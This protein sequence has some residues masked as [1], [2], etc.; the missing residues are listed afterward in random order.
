[1]GCTGS[2]TTAPGKHLPLEKEEHTL[3]VSSS[4]PLPRKPFC[5][6]FCKRKRYETTGKIN[7][8][9]ERGLFDST[10]FDRPLLLGDTK[11]DLY[12]M[13]GS[14]IVSLIIEMLIHIQVKERIEG[15]TK[16]KSPWHVVEGIRDGLFLIKYPFNPFDKVPYCPDR[17]IKNNGRLYTVPHCFWI[18]EYY[19]TGMCECHSNLSAWEWEEQRLWGTYGRSPR[20]SRYQELYVYK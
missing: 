5:E 11:G 9:V 3:V 2:T 6:P 13:M 10:L 1:M 17:M 18:D 15:V 16:L 8:I 14:D 20:E 12:V 19:Y 4:V 7:V